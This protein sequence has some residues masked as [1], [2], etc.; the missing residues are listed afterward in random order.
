MET[1][2]DFVSLD[3]WMEV[4]SVEKYEPEPYTTG[5]G[6]FEKSAQPR[7]VKLWDFIAMLNFVTLACVD[8]KEEVGSLWGLSLE[9]Q[10]GS[11]AQGR[12]QAQCISP[13]SGAWKSPKATF[14]MRKI[15]SSLCYSE[16]RKERQE[17]GMGG[18]DSI[19]TTVPVPHSN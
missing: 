2:D 16:A 5:R 3:T 8:A 14:F 11:D 18:H 1:E 17:I 9:Q 4:K 19:D 7:G 6:Y 15:Q 13:T 12:G 10:S